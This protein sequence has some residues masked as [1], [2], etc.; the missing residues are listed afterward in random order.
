[1]PGIGF[2]A[3]MALMAAIVPFNYPEIRSQR[4]RLENLVDF[5][6]VRI[7]K[8]HTICAIPCAIAG[9]GPPP[10]VVLRTGFDRFRANGNC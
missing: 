3:I 10:S 7:L 1:M 9:Y 6:N 4:D 8:M 5:H 2:G